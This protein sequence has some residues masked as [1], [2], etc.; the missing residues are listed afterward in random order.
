MRFFDSG[1]GYLYDACDLFPSLFVSSGAGM[2]LKA[3]AVTVTLE[4]KQPS[5]CLGAFISRGLSRLKGF[6][7]H[8][9]CADK[10]FRHSGGVGR[11][12]LVDSLPLCLCRFRRISVKWLIF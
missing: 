6:K 1:F 5:V 10:S 4:I 12:R 11:G 9:L 2:W 7:R 3:S 8:E